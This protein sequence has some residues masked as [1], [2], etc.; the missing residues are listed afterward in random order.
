MKYAVLSLLL[1]TTA[2]A[3]TT[4][5]YQAWGTP[6]EGAVWNEIARAFEAGHNTPMPAAQWICT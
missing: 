4:I 6:A 3:D 5:T 1:S 2:N